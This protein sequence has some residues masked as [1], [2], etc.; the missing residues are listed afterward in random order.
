MRPIRSAFL[1]L[2]VLIYS[3]GSAVDHTKEI[4]QLERSLQKE[5]NQET[6]EK[7]VNLYLDMAEA[8]EGE[9]KLEYTGKAGEAA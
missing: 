9:D 4:S 7:L 8:S 6:L 1:L 2:A 5:P 3:C